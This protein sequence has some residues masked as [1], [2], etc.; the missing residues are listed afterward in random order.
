LID[1]A[2][3]YHARP[4][5]VSQ[6]LEATEKN[7][8]KRLTHLDVFNI[9]SDSEWATPTF[10]QSKKTGDVRILTYLR[11]LIA[12]I[13]RKPFPLPNIRAIIF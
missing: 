8:V 10:I 12:Q 2:K 1:G 4:F 11:R 5:H 3:F 7:E 13:K 6:S 9:I